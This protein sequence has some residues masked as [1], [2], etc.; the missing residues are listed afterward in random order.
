MDKLSP[1]KLK[2]PS[3]AAERPNLRN[4]Q[5]LVYRAEPSSQIHFRICHFIK[6]LAPSLEESMAIDFLGIVASYFAWLQR[7]QKVSVHL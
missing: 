2:I 4:T 7:I 3:N 1:L 6:H 5:R